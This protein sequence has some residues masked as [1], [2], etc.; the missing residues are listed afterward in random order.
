MSIVIERI[1]WQITL[2]H[3]FTIQKN[4]KEGGIYANQTKW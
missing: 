3:F 1:Q 4:I 2:N